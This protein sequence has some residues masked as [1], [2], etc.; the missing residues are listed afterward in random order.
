V[1]PREPL[2]LRKLPEEY[3]RR[4]TLGDADIQMRGSARRAK[5]RLPMRA[6]AQRRL[7]RAMRLLRDPAQAHRSITAIAFD[8]GFRDLSHFGRVFTAATEQTPSQWRR[9]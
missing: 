3:D 2:R 6:I 5:E 9:G 7:E 4:D 1:Q 8:C